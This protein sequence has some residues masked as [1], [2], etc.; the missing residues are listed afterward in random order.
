MDKA[1]HQ[2]EILDQFTRQADPFLK[3]HAQGHDAL[4]ALMAHCAATRAEDRILDVACGPGIV[5]CFF[6]AHARHVTGLDMVPAMLERA[7]RL[8]AERCL[9]NVTWQLGES[10]R[11]PFLD[12]SF[13]QV[14]T[15]FSFHHFLDPL[16]ALCE[17]K[18]VCRPAGTVLVSDVTPGKESQARFNEW[19]TLR[20]PSHTRALTVAEFRSLGQEAG[21]NLGRE[22]PFA[23]EMNLDD[24]LKGSFPKRG[25]D[26]RIRALFDNEIRTGSETLGVIA[27]RTEAGI[28]ITY[29]V[30]V[31]AWTR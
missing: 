5:S 20:D 30:S 24:L 21:L 25:D 11:L 27:R 4:L 18:R 3:R 2:A 12:E 6:A 8:Q 7:R 31:L 22:E 28:V 1:A 13:D 16:A 23:M 10:T 15:R 17:M 19:E 29:P 14:V 26:E 9:Q